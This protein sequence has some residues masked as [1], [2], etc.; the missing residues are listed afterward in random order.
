MCRHAGFR[1]GGR[2]GGNSLAARERSAAVWSERVVLFC[3]FVLCIP[4]FCTVVVA[5]PLVSCSVKLPLSRPTGFCL[6]LYI[7]LRTPAGG[8][9]AAWH[10]C[11]WQQPNQNTSSGF[12]HCWPQVVTGTK[13]TA[14][15]GSKRSS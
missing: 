10:F 11:C 1:W 8:G 3:G 13:T 2:R 4:L 14:W 7:V 5:V 9:A 6:F 15:Q 12:C